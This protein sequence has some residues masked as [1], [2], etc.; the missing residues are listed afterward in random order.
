MV[1]ASAGTP[2]D[3]SEVCTDPHSLSG[4]GAP[5]GWDGAE[6]GM[7]QGHPSPGLFTPRSA[8]PELRLLRGRR[9]LFGKEKCCWLF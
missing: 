3:A 6:P 4:V 8:H 1:P 7:G 2:G 5:R 9:K